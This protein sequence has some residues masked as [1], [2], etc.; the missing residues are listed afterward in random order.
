MKRCVTVSMPYHGAMVRR[1]EMRR[2]SGVKPD[3]PSRALA[4]SDVGRALRPT[5]FTLPAEMA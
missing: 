3:P 5:G 2:L 1:D 4:W